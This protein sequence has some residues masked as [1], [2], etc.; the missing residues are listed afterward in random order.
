MGKHQDAVEATITAAAGA[1]DGR[2]TAL[3]ELVRTLAGQ[4]DQAGADPSTRLSAA[5][6][7]TLKDLGRV[8]VAL[9]PVRKGNSL[10][11][12]RQQRTTAGRTARGR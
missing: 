10:E 12:L 1:I 5:Y 2:H 6:L 11:K 7:S 9:A 4:M 3:V 8:T